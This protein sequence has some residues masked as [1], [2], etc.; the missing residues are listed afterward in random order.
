MLDTAFFIADQFDYVH[1]SNQLKRIYG[2]KNIKSHLEKPFLRLRG[3]A[4]ITINDLVNFVR[5]ANGFGDGHTTIKEE[6]ERIQVTR[7]LQSK[8][9]DELVRIYL[10]N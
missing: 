9:P 7:A 5:K 1:L 6:L 4:D 3:Q 2:N 8:M 10:G